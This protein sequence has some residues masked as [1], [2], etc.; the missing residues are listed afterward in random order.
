MEM[1]DIH[2][3]IHELRNKGEMPEH[4]ELAPDAYDALAKRLLGSTTSS[5]GPETQVA[6][7]S[8]TKDPALADGDVAGVL[9]GEKVAV[10][11]IEPTRSVALEVE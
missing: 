5:P 10:V 1:Q 9:Y 6:G 8:V 4:L 2:T 3:A 7:F 11:E